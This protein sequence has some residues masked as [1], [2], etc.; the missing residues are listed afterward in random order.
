MSRHQVLVPLVTPLDMHARVCRQSVQQLVRACG[1]LVD[2]FI[3][4][5]TSG[6]GWNLSAAQWTDMLRYTLEFAD[7][8]HRVVAG[9]ELPT[10][11]EVIERAERAREL[12]AREIIVT[13]PFAPGAS[14]AHILAHYQA[15]H[16][17]T[18][19]DLLVYNESALS[20]NEKS[21]DTLLKIARLERVTGLKDSPS[22]TRTQAQ[23]EQIRGEGVDYFIG[24]EHELAGALVSDGNIV[25]LAN[26][27]P[28][29]CR[30]ACLARQP[31]VAT[32]VAR[33][34]ETFGLGE[35][36]WYAHVKRELAARGVL[37]S[38]LTTQRPGA[39]EHAAHEHILQ[40]YAR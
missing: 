14:Q 15:I 2:G 24:W 17:R 23:I 19:L 28:A 40:E 11:E 30:V 38:A 35:D 32:I 12:G 5:L 4:C 36:D 8:N 7:E 9:I 37:R 34:N 39:H 13:S 20:G 1:P 33:L 29:L 26:L 18:P 27:E 22:Q 21:F 31:E 25:S 10:T 6:E 3:P 16:S